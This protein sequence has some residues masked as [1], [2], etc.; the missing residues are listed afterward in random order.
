MQGYPLVIRPSIP[1][2]PG[3]LRHLL[4]E[5]G[6]FEPVSATRDIKM[7]L[8]FTNRSR[9]YYNHEILVDTYLIFIETMAL[10]FRLATCALH[11]EPK[12]LNNYIIDDRNNINVYRKL[13]NER[14]TSIVDI[15]DGY[16]ETS[17]SN[18]VYNYARNIIQPELG[19]CV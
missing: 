6:H 15:S 16:Y 14:S 11:V 12:G 1:S 19:R 5:L 9:V 4:S 3:A 8:R 2:T 18:N 17:P 13:S 10:Y 7:F